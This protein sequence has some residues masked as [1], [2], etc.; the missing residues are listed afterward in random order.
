[1]QEVTIPDDLPPLFSAQGRGDRN[2]FKAFVEL[3]PHL[4][5]Q[6]GRLGA[7]IP[8]AFASDLGMAPLRALYFDHLSLERWTSFE[9]LRQYFP[10]DSRYKFG[11]IIGTRS[12]QGTSSLGIRSFATEPSELTAT[13]VT[14]DRPMIQKLGGSTRM[15]PELTDTEE[16]WVLE[17]MFSSGRPF[18]Q[19][20]AYGQ[21]IHY[22]RELDLTLDKYAKKFHR[23]ET[24]PKLRRTPEGSFH[25]DDGKTFVPLVE[26][27]MVGRYDIFQK[28][29]V[30]GEG[31]T[32]TWE[33]NRERD[34]SECIPQYVVEPSNERNFRLAICDVTS[35]TNTR[36]V[37]AAL[38]P[39]SWVCGNTAPVLHF[40]TAAAAL[41]SL[42][43]LNSL[44]FDWMA[45]QIVGGLHLNKF[46]LAT[47]VWPK[48]G[49]EVSDRLAE[50]AM[51]MM[52]KAPRNPR[53]IADWFKPEVLRCDHAS[54]AWGIEASIEREVAIAFNLDPEQLRRVLSP[55]RTDRRGFWRYFAANPSLSIAVRDMLRTFS[56]TPPTSIVAA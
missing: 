50:M 42:A 38:V 32:A 46:Y 5:R 39:P 53:W 45:R 2:L 35:A 11:V 40:E 17:R 16:A 33:L 47:L 52:M 30:R 37:H 20:D 4:V 13:H 24:L 22:R 25:S 27:R 41:S 26:G 14:I 28:S 48:L 54:S 8:A 1:M 36:T 43:V 55:D 10:I 29:W 44:V 7:L 23:L 6:G 21:R 3:A 18:F 49:V 12:S 51:A 56:T 9:N 15:L 34:V 31:R 19:P